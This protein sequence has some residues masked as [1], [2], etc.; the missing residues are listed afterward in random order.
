M[1]TKLDEQELEIIRQAQQSC[2]VRKTKE[3]IISCPFKW[4]PL[5]E[6]N[7]IGICTICHIW[8]GTDITKTD[9]PCMEI[10]REETITRFWRPAS[11]EE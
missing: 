11:K 8:I 3:E 2:R 9:H 6:M 5:D 7:S 1:K 10:G 4:T